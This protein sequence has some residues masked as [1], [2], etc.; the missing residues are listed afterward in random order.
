MAVKFHNLKPR[1]GAYRFVLYVLYLDDF[2]VMSYSTRL[3]DI[4]PTLDLVKMANTR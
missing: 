1:S 2:M 4:N 3:P